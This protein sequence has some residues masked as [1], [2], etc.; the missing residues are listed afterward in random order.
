MRQA[1]LLLS[2]LLLRPPSLFAGPNDMPPSSYSA[3]AIRGIVIDASTGQP[4]DGVIIVAQWVLI[5]ANVGGH[6]ARRRL[7][8]LET[9]T[10]QDG[11]YA[12]PAWGP[13]PNP[14]DINLPKGYICCFL[15]DQ[16][17]ALS[18]FKPGYRP[19]GLENTKPVD[20]A[21]A[22]RTS[23]WDGK[24]IEL[25]PFKGSVEEWG[26]EIGFLQ[27]D[28]DWGNLDW[29]LYPRMVLAI[30]EQRVRYRLSHLRVSD[31]ESLG[32]TKQEILRELE[33]RP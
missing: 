22:V 31:L 28:L 30:E 33:T 24:R 17:P 29:H 5:E 26:K 11:S 6:T 16:D 20:V 21:P 15:W 25:E 23:D 19:L 7:Q 13:I 12:F 2:L 10:A 9:V 27:T 8:V 4:M 18:Y 3:Q 14:L 1:V 32:T